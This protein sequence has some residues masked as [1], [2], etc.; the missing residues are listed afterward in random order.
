MREL[1]VS[2]IDQFDF[3][4]QVPELNMPATRE[5]AATPAKSASQYRLKAQAFSSQKRRLQLA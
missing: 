1:T 4:G 2:E 3:T 5:T